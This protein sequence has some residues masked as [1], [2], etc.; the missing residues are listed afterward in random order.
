MIKDISR[1]CA[2]GAITA[3]IDFSALNLLIHLKVE[4]HISIAI[5][6]LLAASVAYYLNSRW[7]YGRLEKEPSFASLTKYL[8]IYSFGLVLTE[9]IIWSLANGRGFSINMAKA[10]A[11]IMVF[12]WN[13][14]ANRYW[15]YRS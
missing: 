2:V 8:S 11:I 6:Y 3:V 13:F 5:G 7:T 12:F 14:F 4:T 9:I 10:A 1:F 15:T